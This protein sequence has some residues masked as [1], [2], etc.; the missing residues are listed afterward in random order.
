MATLPE[1]LAVT[2][3]FSET[4]NCKKLQTTQFFYHLHL[5]FKRKFEPM[6]YWKITYSVV[7]VGVSCKINPTVEIWMSEI[8]M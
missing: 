1:G 7:L 8:K 4:V 6:L 3:V 5:R 2:A